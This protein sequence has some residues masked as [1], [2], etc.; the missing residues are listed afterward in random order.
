MPAPLTIAFLSSN[1]DF[2]YLLPAFQTQF[3]QARLRLGTELGPL[4]DIDAAVCW[5]P[6]EGLLARLPRLRLIQSV[7]AGIDHIT[8]DPALPEVPVCRIIDPDMGQ[9]MTAYVT[10]AVIQHQRHMGA[11]LRSAAA[12]RWEEQPVQPPRQHRVGI[13]G[14]GTL[15]LACAE[16]LLNIGYSV[17]G[18]SRTPKRN[19]QSELPAGLQAFHGE[20]GQAEFLAGCDT[21]VCLLPLTED[22]RGILGQPLFNQLPRGAHLINVGRG[23]HLVE[24]DLLA[25]PASGQLAAA[26]LDALTQEP[27]PPEH[28]FWADPRI[29]ITPHIA[30]RTDP[31][32]IARQTA[33]N[34][35]LVDAGRAAEVAVDLQRGY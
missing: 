28:P 11:Y 1:L 16:A 2:S 8:A 10:W 23:A 12:R 20:A 14:L 29:L 25:A 26:T 22:T 18:W 6:P 31:A 9:G 5:Y 33:D 30:T 24:A 34:L 32:V 21:L 35:A 15:G 27:L 13:A 17:R 3:P 4:E 19:T 7:G